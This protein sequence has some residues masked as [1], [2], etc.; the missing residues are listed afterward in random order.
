MKGHRNKSPLDLK[1]MEVKF[2]KLDD[3]V[4]RPVGKIKAALNFALEE[5]YHSHS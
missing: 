4:P 3:N 1:F 2:L 5:G